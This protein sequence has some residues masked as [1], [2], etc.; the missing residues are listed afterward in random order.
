M[1]CINNTL[2]EWSNE[3]FPI[4]YQAKEVEDGKEDIDSEP[5]QPRLFG[6]T[7]KIQQTDDQQTGK[8][9]T[10]IV[11]SKMTF[12]TLLPNVEYLEEECTDH[13]QRLAKQQG[14][15]VQQ[16]RIGKA[17]GKRLPCVSS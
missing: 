17:T 7:V 15:Y 5:M 6:T 14:N 1:V 16:T 4:T 2:F 13:W 8:N 12:D 3:T 9:S 10:Y 11:L